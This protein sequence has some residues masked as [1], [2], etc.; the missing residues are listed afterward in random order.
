M[1]G[2][3]DIKKFKILRKD[4]LI[5]IKRARTLDDIIALL[6]RKIKEYAG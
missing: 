6:A 1:S 4:L 3:T 5:G 2:V